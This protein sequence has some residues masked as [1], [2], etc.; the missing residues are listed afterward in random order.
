M[1]EAPESGAFEL[2]SVGWLARVVIAAVPEASV[3]VF[4]RDLSVLVAEGSGYGRHGMRPEAI[5]GRAIPDVV[6]ATAWRELRE[7]YHAALGGARQSFEYESS[8]GLARYWIH[9][10]PV[11]D[12]AGA[13]VGGVL[14]SQ[15][16]TRRSEREEAHRIEVEAATAAFLDAPIGMAVLT[17]DGRFLRVNPALCRMLGQSSEALLDTDY[18]E[19]QH[20]EERDESAATLVALRSGRMTSQSERRYVRADATEAWGLVSTTLL[21]GS[22]D[23]PD[24]LFAQ[25]QDVTERHRAEQQLRRRLFQQSAVAELGRRALDGTSREALVEAATEALG[26]TLDVEVTSFLELAPKGDELVLRAGRGWRA[27]ELGRM[28]VPTTSASSAGFALTTRRPVV[29]DDL[30]AEKRFEAPILR[31]QGI[32]SS[33]SVLVGQPERPIGVLGAHARETEAFSED[34]VNFVEAVANVLAETIER[35]RAEARA[36]HQERHD[37]L[38]G[39]P[40][41]TAF[42]AQV[43]EALSGAASSAE[44]IGVFLVDLDDFQIVNDSLGQR[45][46]D[47]LLRAVAD[48][49]RE[50][51]RTSDVLARFGGDEFAVLSSA[52]PD[53]DSATEVAERMCRAFTRPFAVDG[54]AHYLEASVGVVV[55]ACSGG[56][57][58]ALLRDAGAA[59]ERA[60]I[61]ARGCWEL[62]EEPRRVARVDRLRLRNELR[63]ALSEGELRVVYQPFYAVGDGRPVG[64]EALVR[65]AHPERGLLA[66]SEFLPLAEESGLIIELGEWVLGEACAQGARLRERLDPGA[67]FLL[68]VNVAARQVAA[69]GLP[70]MVSAALA[71]SGLPAGCLGLE[72]SE[73]VIGESRVDVIAA[74]EALKRVGARILLD[75]FGT[76]FS[77]LW[78]LGRLPIDIVKI[79]RSF[80]DQLAVPDSPDGAIVQAILGMADAM[81]KEVIAEGVE[82]GEQ[83]DSLRSLGCRTAQGFLL[84]HPLGAEEFGAAVTGAP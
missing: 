36:H 74:L 78:R 13:I 12:E 4:D 11:E 19:L 68:T 29:S 33:V 82:T 7:R 56:G 20:P 6:P 22:R 9:L 5:L 52:L 75:D 70:G 14:V 35:H 44:R 76:G 69:E 28:S 30:R 47:E 62:H 10:S 34:D 63:R 45:A 15:D 49:L 84:A 16:V 66:P 81:G 27:S 58:H 40:N 37:A 24:V 32:L 51:V 71:R 57:A 80:V 42:L 1:S 2:E 65:W 64:A 43:E 72:V 61:H 8:D 53:R 73:G 48:R 54:E 38:T 41:R 21:R 55:G 79:D 18:R 31:E 3:V 23:R 17:L 25:V 39:L 50:E 26:E 67:P 77:S 83:L 46:G 60:K 59:L